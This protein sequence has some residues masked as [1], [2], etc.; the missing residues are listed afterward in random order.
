MVVAGMGYGSSRPSS[1][2]M[3]SNRRKCECTLLA[4]C[5]P[6][7]ARSVPQYQSPLLYPSTAHRVAC[8]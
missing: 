7:Y 4:H 5:P 1:F 6:P 3:A 2:L 8:A